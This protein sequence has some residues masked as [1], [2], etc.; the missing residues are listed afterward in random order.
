M[1]MIYSKAAMQE[2]MIREKS[3]LAQLYL[4]ESPAITKKIIVNATEGQINL[5]IQVIFT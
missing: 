5:L 2:C 4:S 3:F 1:L